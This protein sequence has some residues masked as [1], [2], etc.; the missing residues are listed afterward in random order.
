MGQSSSSVAGCLALLHW[1]FSL[2]VENS[3]GGKL[4]SSPVCM[5]KSNGRMIKDEIPIT[6]SLIGFTRS[7]S[8]CY[9]WSF[10]WYDGRC[11]EGELPQNHDCLKK[12][13][14]LDTPRWVQRQEFGPKTISHIWCASFSIGML[15]NV[16]L[17]Y[18]LER[19]SYHLRITSEP[20][21]FV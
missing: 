15:S 19:V 11:G 17:S 9:L 10:R 18:K 7:L 13:D 2:D 1:Y 20:V 5:D 3:W 12:L 21:G 6:Q 16:R 14:L 8:E 4:D